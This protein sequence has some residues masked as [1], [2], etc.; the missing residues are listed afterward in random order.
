MGANH[1]FF[2]TEWTPGH[3]GRAVVRRLGRRPRRPV[4]SAAPRAPQGRRP[5]RRRARPTSPAP[6]RLFTGRRRLPAAPRRLARDRALDRRRRRPQPR[7]RRRPRHAP[8]GHRGHA[9]PCRRRAPTRGCATARRPSTPRRFGKCG[10]GI[11]S[12]ITPHWT[13]DG[14][15]HAVAAV[16]RDVVDAGGR[17]RRPALR[18]PARPAARPARAAHDRRPPAGPGRPAG[19]GHRRQR[20]QRHPHARGRLGGRA[21]A[22]GAVPHQAVGADAARRRHRRLGRRPGRHRARSSWSRA[23]PAAGS[24][25]PTSPPPPPRSRPC[26]ACGCRRSTSAT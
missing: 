16:L 17:R 23:T 14:E 18:R 2:N 26:P 12:E 13:V 11:R 7:H 9:R 4:R 15:A 20:R 22:E 3:V 1:N 10:R 24:G 5:A 19:A 25:S 8:P 6:S 21:A